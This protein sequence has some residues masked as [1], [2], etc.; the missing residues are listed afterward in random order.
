MTILKASLLVISWVIY[1]CPTQFPNFHSAR[2]GRLILNFFLSQFHGESNADCA[3]RNKKG[4]EKN[5]IIEVAHLKLHYKK[6]DS[7]SAKGKMQF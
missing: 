6:S 1:S 7:P 4:R 2:E 3:A 5:I